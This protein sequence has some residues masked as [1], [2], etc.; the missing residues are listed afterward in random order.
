[1]HRS[2]HMGGS[3]LHLLPQP[4]L[5]TASKQITE[6]QRPPHI[7][8][9]A[10]PA[11]RSTDCLKRATRRIRPRPWADHLTAHVDMTQREFSTANPLEC[12]I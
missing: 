6:G 9:K 2:P 7:K 12:V 1:M 10:L 5:I 3:H 8:D 11:R 4:T